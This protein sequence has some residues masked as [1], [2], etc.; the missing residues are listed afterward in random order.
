MEL[1]IKKFFTIR[2]AAIAFVAFLFFILF[3]PVILKL[4][5]SWDADPNYSHGFFI[6]FIS[7]YFVYTKLEVIKKTTPSSSNKGFWIVLL[8]LLLFILGWI[9]SLDFVQGISMLIVLW[10]SILYLFGK[11]VGKLITF[12]VFY[13][14]FMIPLPAIVWNRLSVPLSLIASSISSRLMEFLGMVVYREG[15]II[16]LPNITLQVVEACSGLRSLVTLMALS[17]GLAYISNFSVLKKII[18]FLCAIPIAIV[19]NVIRLTATGI[20]AENFGEQM[21]QG[22]IHEFSGWV[23]FLIG[24][25]LL[26]LVQGILSKNT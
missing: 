2:N 9:S 3:Q 13:L 14:I 7:F 10:G 6:P 18:L 24:F 20:L 11:E 19:G 21:A 5:E 22:F 8:G 23:V 17:A 1:R 12:P 26:L 15:N 25:F 4:I 16:T